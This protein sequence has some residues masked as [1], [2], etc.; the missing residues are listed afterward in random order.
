MAEYAVIIPT[1]NEKDN[2]LPTIKRLE[3]VLADLDWEVVF[4]DD[5]SSDGTWQSL[6]GIAAQNP[7]VRL[8]RRVGRRGLSSACVEGMLA[9]SA[10]YLAVMDADLQHDAA[11]LPRMFEAL[12][13]GEATVAV[14]S[15]YCDAGGIGEWDRTRAKM[16]RLATGLASRV[17]LA[18][19]S[20]PMSGFFAL[21]RGII[22]AIASKISLSGFKILFDIL[23]TPGIPLKVKE[24]PYTFCLRIH[25][26]TKLRLSTL[27]DFAWLLLKKLSFRL[28]ITNF[29]MFC[30]V[31][32]SGVLVHFCVLYGAHKML[33]YS[34]LPS[35]CLA[36]LSAMTSNYIIN[37]KLTFSSTR[38]HG[39]EFI[40][41]YFLFCLAC[42]FGALVNIAISELLYGMSF[43]SWFSAAAIGIIAGSVV[44]YLTSKTFVWK[45]V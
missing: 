43:F 27:I 16:S 11:I 36:I 24:I 37:N 23:T 29:L 4:V 31:G 6:L 44:N 17:L 8:L 12:S 32:F 26:S 5:D 22:D 10:R 13:S 41:G 40:K 18:P 2:I 20:D 7:R 33:Q 1:L 30:L 42:T 28:P 9:T 35:Q 39:K 14:G 15:R 34:F 3:N 25:G 45:G 19:C 38:L 21:E